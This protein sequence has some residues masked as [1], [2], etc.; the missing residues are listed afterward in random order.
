MY[1]YFDFLR[2]CTSN[3]YQVEVVVVVV[4]TNS[5]VR[6][7]RGLQTFN[8]NF[9]KFPNSGSDWIPYSA[10]FVTHLREVIFNLCFIIVINCVTKLVLFGFPIMRFL[11]GDE[12]ICK[13]NCSKLK[14]C[15]F[16]RFN[17]NLG[18]LKFYVCL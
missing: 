7:L 17:M 18:P 4:Q 16:I 2:T 6:S 9:M 8:L 14:N 12:L 13:F 3:I 10:I 11:K 1:V 15:E 5:T